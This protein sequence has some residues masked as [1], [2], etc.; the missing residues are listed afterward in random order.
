MCASL[1]KYF[2]IK[3]W[4][5]ENVRFFATVFVDPYSWVVWTT[6]ALSDMETERFRSKISFS[7]AKEV[8]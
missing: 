4:R 3:T 7:A 1:K 6:A 8:T 2:A 5:Q